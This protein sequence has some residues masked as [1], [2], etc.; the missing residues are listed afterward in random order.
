MQDI[1]LE[2]AERVENDLEESMAFEPPPV[3]RAA[4]QQAGA[5][6]MRPLSDLVRMQVG[7]RTL[8]DISDEIRRCMLVEAV[9]LN[10]GN[11]T[12]TASML[13]LTRQAVQQM[14]SNLGLKGWA[15]KLRETAGR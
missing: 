4:A 2:R 1:E 9:R 8:S 7:R 5:E 14:L 13:G 12:K 6:L 11:I 10:R 3:V 15:S